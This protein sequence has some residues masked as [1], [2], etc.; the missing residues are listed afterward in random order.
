MAKQAGE[1]SQHELGRVGD[2]PT[3]DLEN[4]FKHA[5]DL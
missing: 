3:G 4:E 2:E 1:R 5:N